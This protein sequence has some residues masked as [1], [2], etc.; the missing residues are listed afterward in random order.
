M[1]CCQAIVIRKVKHYDVEYQRCMRGF[2]LVL[3]SKVKRNR[4]LPF[5]ELLVK[6]ANSVQ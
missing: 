5:F 2:D 4:I 6:L 1:Y 3:W